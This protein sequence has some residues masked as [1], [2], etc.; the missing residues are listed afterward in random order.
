[1]RDVQIVMA[2]EADLEVELPDEECAQLITVRD[3]VEYLWREG[4]S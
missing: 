2:I 4:T 1:M 3:L